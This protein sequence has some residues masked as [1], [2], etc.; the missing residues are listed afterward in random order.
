MIYNVSRE[1]FGGAIRMGDMIATANIVEHLRKVGSSPQI[2]FYFTP[3]TINATQY[4][5]DFHDWLIA[6]TNYFTVD[7]GHD[8]LPWKKVNIWDYRDISG[9]LVQIKNTH[10]IEKKIVVCPLFD[11]QYNTYRNWPGSVF[12]SIIAYC[13]EKYA[14]LEKILCVG[15]DVQ[16]NNITGWGLSTDLNETLT[17]IMQSQVYIGGD[18]GLSHFAG[19][20]DRGPEPIYWV[21]SRGL[22]HTT[23]INWY[24]K[25]KGTLRT[26]WLDFENTKW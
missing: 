10:A 12:N 15:P 25:K 14:G 21:S 24:T 23:P 13:N 26:Y 11:A 4:C 3:G 18:T 9:D 5:H 6:N 1:T 16:I 20:L 7:S 19:A 8:N 17:H 22:I 2:K